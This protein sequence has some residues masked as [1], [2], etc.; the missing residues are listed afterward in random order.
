MDQRTKSLKM[1]LKETLMNSRFKKQQ[2]SIMEEPMMTQS[3]GI[4]RTSMIKHLRSN[5]SYNGPA[6]DNMSAL[7]V[8]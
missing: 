2:T 8:P 1:N 5:S 6:R 4:N 7:G 3:S